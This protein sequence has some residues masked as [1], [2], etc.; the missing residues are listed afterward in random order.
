MKRHPSD[1]TLRRLLDEPAGVADADRRH[2]ADCPVCLAGVAAAGED[3]ALITSALAVDA[4]ADVDEGW[5][6]LSGALA[7]EPARPVTTAARGNRW[8]AALR[9][10]VI[11]VVGVVALLTGASA[12]AAADWF[13]I[14]KAEKIAP[15]TVTQ[16]DLLKLPE[17]SAYGE[18]KINQKADIRAVPDAA[19]AREAT[20]LAVARVGKLP[21]GVA[22]EPQYLVGNRVSASF[23]FSTAKAAATARAAG[24]ALPPPPPGLDGS[25]FRL[26][27]GPGVAA[28]WQSSAGLPSLVVL[29]ANAPTGF[30]EGVPFATARDYLLSMP[31]LPASVASQ[32]RNFTA[33]GSTLPL[34]VKQERERSFSTDV[35]GAQAT[36]LTSRDQVLSGVAWVEKGV[37]TAVGGSLSSDEVVEVARGL[38]W[39]S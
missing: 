38:R 29:R 1:G 28:V 6:R 23:T 16:A 26:T 22:G 21:R 4:S 5:R 3:A 12:A 17:L 8:R 32:L 19:A 15:V 11:A 35:N 31:G 20:G 14:F 2:V 13:Q 33:D 10:P 27:A 9:S 7:A 18:M 36:V 37:L 24:Q 34:L 25:E 30:S 39:D